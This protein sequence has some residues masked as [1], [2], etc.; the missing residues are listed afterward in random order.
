MA[1]PSDKDK[2]LYNKILDTLSNEGVGGDE[3]E[4]EEDTF[5]ESDSEEELDGSPSILSIHQDFCT[6]FEFLPKDQEEKFERLVK[7]FH[8]NNYND[9]HHAY[10]EIRQ[11]L[12]IKQTGYSHVSDLY[13]SGDYTFGYNALNDFLRDDFKSKVLNDMKDPELI[14]TL[15]EDNKLRGQFTTL[16]RVYAPELSVD[17]YIN[18]FLHSYFIFDE[19][20]EH[21]ASYNG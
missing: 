12:A 18:Q 13:D 11:Y 17:E 21:V 10:R 2:E 16:Q 15:K 3:P 1:T 5:P 20:G 7:D 9:A 19:I 8:S 6:G 14:P 4:S